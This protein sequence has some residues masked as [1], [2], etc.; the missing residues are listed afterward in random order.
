MSTLL[1]ALPAEFLPAFWVFLGFVGAVG[2]LALISPSA[3][4]TLAVRGGRWVDTSKVIAKLD[5][6]IELDE[7]VLPYSRFLGAAVL[8]AVAV[9]AYMFAR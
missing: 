6:R 5:K 9:L 3:F 4:A 1:A 8:V 2:L 7:R